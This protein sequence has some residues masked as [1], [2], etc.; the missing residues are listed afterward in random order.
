[1]SEFVNYVALV[2]AHGFR[3]WWEWVWGD[4]IIGLVVT[5]GTALFGTWLLP[6]VTA[7]FPVLRRFVAEDTMDSIVNTVCRRYNRKLWTR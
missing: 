3:T 7:Y 6:T 2:T 5:L 1:M 4:T